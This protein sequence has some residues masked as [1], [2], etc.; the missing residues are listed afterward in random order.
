[1][2]DSYKVLDDGNVE[3]IDYDDKAQKSIYIYEY[4]D[5]I[6]DV[7]KEENI[8]EYLEYKKERINNQIKS[9]NVALNRN[10]RISKLWL[11]SV[12]LLEI[13]FGYAF[14][15]LKV[16]TFIGGLNVLSFA[17]FIF[18]TIMSIPV[19]SSTFIGINKFKKEN[20][21][22]EVELEELEK[23]LNLAKDKINTLLN[24][25]TKCNQEIKNNENDYKKISKDELNKII[26]YLRNYYVA[27]YYEKEFYNCYKN[28]ILEKQLGD[29]FNY[30]ECDT[31]VVMKYFKE[32]GPVLAKKYNKK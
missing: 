14:S 18:G 16:G 17:P 28:G 15:L 4:Q 11:I 1:M 27:G 26:N 30:I 31:P 20:R 7:L 10:K 24:D 19:L 13:L 6:E 3:V 23:Q 12:I 5:N 8:K 25:K 21:G 32:K 29:D 2:K 9:I 22:F